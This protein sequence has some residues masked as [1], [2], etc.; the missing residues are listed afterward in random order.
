MFVDIFIEDIK[1]EVYQ[2]LYGHKRE[3]VA[4][5]ENLL[6]DGLITLKKS[7]VP[8]LSEK[9]KKLIAFYYSSR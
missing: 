4:L 5:I 1:P 3:Y 2:K 8:S 6:Q 7:G 9:G